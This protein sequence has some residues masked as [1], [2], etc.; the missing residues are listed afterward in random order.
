MASEVGDKAIGEEA[1]LISTQAQDREKLTVK[2][3]D[4]LT[5]LADEDDNGSS[6]IFVHSS[7]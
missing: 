6:S 1:L 3:T 7:R 2:Y 5:R 4:L